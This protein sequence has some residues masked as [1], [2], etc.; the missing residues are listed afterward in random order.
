MKY[1]LFCICLILTFLSCKKE[2]KLSK[3]S[4]EGKWKLTEAFRNDKRTQ[5]LSGA[6]YQFKDTMLTTN[7]FGDV[8]STGYSLDKMD[9]VQRVPQEIRYTVSMNP[10]QTLSFLTMIDG[11]AFKFTLKKE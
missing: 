1:R 7:I 11:I 6:F 8:I 2:A 5:T 4:L 10:D 9:V 3:E